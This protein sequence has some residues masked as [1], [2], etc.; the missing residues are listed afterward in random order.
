MTPGVADLL[1]H[2]ETQTP[3]IFRGWTDDPISKTGWQQMLSAVADDHWDRI[4]SSPLSRCSEFAAHLGKK[5]GL[6]VEYDENFKEYNFGDWDGHT[7][8]EVMADQG[9]LVTAFFQ[10]PEKSPPPNGE[11]FSLFKHRV[12]TAWH[13]VLDESH[14]EKTLIISHGGVIMTVLADVMGVDRL[15]GKIE[16]SYACRTQLRLDQLGKR[17]RLIFHK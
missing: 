7:Y 1:R 14:L 11:D 3:D 17:P 2:G 4:V 12:L 8:E 15:H 5:F 10:D 16:M 13:A 9:H 6:N